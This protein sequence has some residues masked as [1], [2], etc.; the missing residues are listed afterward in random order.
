MQARVTRAVTDEKTV[1]LL[2]PFFL[3]FSPF[4]LSVPLA[5]GAKVRPAIVIGL[6]TALLTVVRLRCVVRNHPYR[7][8]FAFHNYENRGPAGKGV[9]PPALRSRIPGVSSPEQGWGMSHQDR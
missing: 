8:V 2:P 4:V 5:T 7:F 6:P 9:N 3:S 1:S